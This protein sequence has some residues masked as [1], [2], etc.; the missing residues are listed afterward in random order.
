M[1]APLEFMRFMTN[2]EE[3]RIALLEL[4]VQI[5]RKM[6]AL[7]TAPGKEFS[8]I[9]LEHHP[10]VLQESNV[11]DLTS[12]GRINSKTFRTY[13][14]YYISPRPRIGVSLRLPAQDY[15]VDVISKV[16][17]EPI[18][19]DLFTIKTFG[20]APVVHR[21]SLVPGTVS[22]LLVEKARQWN[23]GATGTPIAKHADSTKTPV[24]GS[25]KECCVG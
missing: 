4:G 1:T 5:C 8:H 6:R 11:L 25:G 3:N 16:H 12:D 20:I 2:A 9:T 23:A 13:L 10:V 17:S 7:E 18:S 15:Y 24:I 14:R 19:D 21:A 22:R